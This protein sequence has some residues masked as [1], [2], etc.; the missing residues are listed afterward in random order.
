MD[1][2]MEALTFQEDTPIPAEDDWFAPLLG[3]WAF[4]YRDASRQL[5]GEWYFRRVL[6]GAGIEDVFICPSRATR[7]TQA[8]PDGEYGAA[9]RMYDAAR[10]CYNMVYTCDHK[11][12]HLEVRR[13]NSRIECT[14]LANPH[15][16]WRF[17]EITPTTFHWQNVTVQLDGT[18]HINCEVFATRLSDS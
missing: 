13:V 18:V 16:K 17:C 1:R 15:V 7:H 9:L 8:Q 6:N 3:N 4:D 11:M 5:K 2:F 12:D 14:V 10:H